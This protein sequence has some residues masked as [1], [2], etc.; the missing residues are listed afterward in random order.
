MARAQIRTVIEFMAWLDA[1]VLALADLAQPQLELWLVTTPQT[2]HKFNRCIHPL[3]ERPPADA[4][5]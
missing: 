4:P 3:D 2:H 1:N 5:A